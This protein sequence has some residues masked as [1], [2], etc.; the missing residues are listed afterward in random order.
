[1]TGYT[2]RAAGLASKWG[3]GDGDGL[4]DCM[5]DLRD[6]GLITSVPERDSILLAAVQRYL[7]PELERRGVSVE[8][9][10]IGSNHNP[11]RAETVNGAEVDWH[12]ESCPECLLD[13]EVQISREDL[14]ALAKEAAP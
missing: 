5:Y 3:F 11:V 12:A 1:M 2:L 9:V 8:I 7:L 14:I 4:Q 13:I 10:A 6:E